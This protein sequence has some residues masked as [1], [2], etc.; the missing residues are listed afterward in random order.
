VIASQVVGRATV[1]APRLR[2][3]GEH[4]CSVP[5]LVIASLGR[6]P[7]TPLVLA[8]A[9]AH[10]RARAGGAPSRSPW[11]PIRF[12]R[13]SAGR[14]MVRGWP[15]EVDLA[16]PRGRDG[17][18]SL[19]R[20][21]PS[22]GGGSPKGP[23]RQAAALPLI[24][25]FRGSDPSQLSHLVLSVASGPKSRPELVCM[26]LQAPGERAGSSQNVRARSDLRGKRPKASCGDDICASRGP[27]IWP[28]GWPNATAVG[29]GRPRP[30][31]KLIVGRRRDK[32][33]VRHP[34]RVRGREPDTSGTERGAHH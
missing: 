3:D 33:K 34:T 15:C 16:P 10:L 1:G 20:H 30:R 2:P 28:C 9:Q 14:K 29:R 7:S 4:P 11:A 8:Q 25:S 26:P 5:F 19:G 32:F 12:P 27:G 21:S 22:R 23:A 17:E 31:P 6:C 24:A 13:S 18:A